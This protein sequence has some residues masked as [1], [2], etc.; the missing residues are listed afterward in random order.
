MK[1][2]CHAI[3]LEKYLNTQKNIDILWEQEVILK[4]KK[5]KR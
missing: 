1:D 3:P 4:W 2:C 5:E